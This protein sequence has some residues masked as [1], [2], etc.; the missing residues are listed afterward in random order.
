[1]NYIDIIVLIIVILLSLRGFI[2]GLIYEILSIIGLVLGAYLGATY[3]RDVGILFDKHALHFTSTFVINA[4]GFAIV[5]LVVWIVCLFIGIFISRF[6]LVPSLSF[7]NKIL[8][9]LFGLV[10]NFIILSLIVFGISY[11]PFFMNFAKKAQK[12]STTF[13]LMI[14]T[15]G[16]ILRHAW[17]MDEMKKVDL[18]NAANIKDS[19]NSATKAIQNKLNKTVQD[20]GGQGKDAIN[21][22]VNTNLDEVIDK[23]KDKVENPNSNLMD[24]KTD[25]KP[26]SPKPISEDNN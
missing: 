1:M 18:K 12:E 15:G 10:K 19:V 21:N 11:T 8:G 25:S 16:G 20:L 17:L 26:T 4:I 5:F 23:V 13:E 7:L 6:T 24:T 3:G 22:A 14:Q 2:N 9:F